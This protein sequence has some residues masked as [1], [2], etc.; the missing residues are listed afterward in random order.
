V[1]LLLAIGTPPSWVTGT[2]V[3]QATLVGTIGALGGHLIA[4]P[5]TT[6]LAARLVDARS[7]SGA[8]GAVRL[9]ADCLRGVAR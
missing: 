8:S 9:A 4:A 5:L 1:G 3:V 6:R 7:F 2:H